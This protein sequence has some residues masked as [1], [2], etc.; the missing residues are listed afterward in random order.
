M[1][2]TLQGF[3]KQIQA[4]VP[5]QRILTDLLSL[6]AYAHDASHYVLVPK[7]VIRVDNEPELRHIL[8]AAQQY[9]IPVTFR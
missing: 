1:G 3:L 6:H 7:A 8:K 4:Y 2:H 9:Q 5:K